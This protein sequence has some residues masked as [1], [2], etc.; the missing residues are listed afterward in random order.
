MGSLEAAEGRTKGVVDHARGDAAW[1]IGYMSPEDYSDDYI[2]EIDLNDYKI[3][4]P[5]DA[6]YGK[7]GIPLEAKVHVRRLEGRRH[8]VPDPSR[9]NPAVSRNYSDIVANIADVKHWKEEGYED[10]ELSKSVK[11]TAGLAP[12]DNIDSKP[13]IAKAQAALSEGRPVAYKNYVEDT[14]NTSFVVP[15]G[16]A[17]SWETDVM[18]D[19][20]A[21]ES[22]KAYARQRQAT[23][24]AGTTE[25]DLRPDKLEPQ[26]T[27]LPIFGLSHKAFPAEGKR[28][29][30]QSHQFN[31]IFDRERF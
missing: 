21:P 4:D 31:A 24:K 1:A 8:T 17:R 15:R 13:H 28:R 18:L 16:A 12:D 11:Q 9:N 26:A 23:G 30:L 6:D 20:S 5:D 2:H 27:Q 10:W 14:G 25:F 19:R 22:L 3:T 7:E 29:T